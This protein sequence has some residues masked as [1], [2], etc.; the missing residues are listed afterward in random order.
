M[1]KALKSGNAPALAVVICANIF[2]YTAIQAGATSL[3]SDWPSI[4]EGA[5][6]FA[7]AGIV[8]TIIFVINGLISAASKARIVFLRWNDPLPGSEAFTR[9]LYTDPRISVDAIEREYGALPTHP[10][11]QNALWYRLYKQVS[12]DSAVLQTHRAYLFTRDYAA[13]AFMLLVILGPIAVIQ[14]SDTKIALSY[15]AVLAAQLA[16]SIQAA[17]NYGKRLVTTVLALVSARV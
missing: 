13:I 7:T 2:G 5:G 11:E 15:C 8:V 17:R 6:K 4:V 3:N 9:Y 12:M 16:L 14:S 1:T 10:R